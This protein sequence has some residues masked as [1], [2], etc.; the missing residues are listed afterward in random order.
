MRELA[1]YSITYF[2]LFEIL[3]TKQTKITDQIFKGLLYHIFAEQST[4]TTAQLI[5]QN[6]PAS[7]HN[8]FRTLLSTTIAIVMF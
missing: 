2:C 4:V 1:T 8:L 3:K 6:G 7:V 5:N